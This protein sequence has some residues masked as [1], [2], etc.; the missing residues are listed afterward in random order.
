MSLLMGLFVCCLALSCCRL[1][2]VP[3]L[4]FKLGASNFSAEAAWIN[5]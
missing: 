3:Y 4:L 2:C 5:I 1:L